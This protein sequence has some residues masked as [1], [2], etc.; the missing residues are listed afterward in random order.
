MKNVS[1][2]LTKATGFER[3]QRILWRTAFLGAGAAATAL[4]AFFYPPAASAIGL[5]LATLEILNRMTQR[6][7]PGDLKIPIT[8]SPEGHRPPGA[9]H[10][11]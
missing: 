5:G 4:A 3:R 8:N 7:E 2:P 1:A 10:R 9:A 11:H 6:A